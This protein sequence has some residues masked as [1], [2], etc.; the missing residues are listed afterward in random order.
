MIHLVPPISE[1]YTYHKYFLAHIKQYIV[2][3]KAKTC[4]FKI[5]PVVKEDFL[6]ICTVKYS[7]PPPTNLLLH[8]I[9]YTFNDLRIVYWAEQNL[10][11]EVLVPPLQNSEIF[12]L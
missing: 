9:F 6:I 7:S 8:R 3:Y 2:G 12:D 1:H 11:K 10:P 5:H 4:F